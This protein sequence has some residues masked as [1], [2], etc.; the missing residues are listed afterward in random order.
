MPLVVLCGFPCSGKS[1]RALELQEYLIQSGK[2]V[3]IIG[4]EALGVNR[5]D[6]YAD[7]R[8]EKDVRGSLRAEVERKLNKEDV[9]ILDSLNYIKGYRYELFCLIKHVQTPHCLI[10][11]ITAPEISSTWNQERDKNEQ[12]T[13]EIFDALVQ[14]FEAPDSRNRWDSPLF[15]VHKEEKLPMEQICSAIFHRRA[16]PPNQS[17]QT[18]P[19]SSTNF[20]HEL[21]KVTQDVVTAVLNAQ[22]T[23]IPGDVIAVPGASER[24]SF[25]MKLPRILN[26][27]EL[28]RLRQQFISYTKLH[29]NENISQLANMFV[30]SLEGRERTLAAAEGEEARRKERQK[31]KQWGRRSQEQRQRAEEE[32]LSGESDNVP[33]VVRDVLGEGST[34]SGE[35]TSS[36][37]S[38]S[39]ST[40]SESDSDTNANVQGNANRKV[41]G[42]VRKC[43]R[44]LGDKAGKRKGSKKGVD[45]GKSVKLAGPGGTT[46]CA[47]SNPYDH[48]PKKI[49]RRI[50]SGKFVD[51]FKLTRQAVNGRDGGSKGETGEHRPKHIMDWVR[52]FY[53]FSSFYLLCHPE[54]AMNVMRYMDLITDTHTVYGGTAWFEYDRAFRLKMADNEDMT[55]GSR[56]M[57]L[58]SGLVTHARG[59]VP[60]HTQQRAPLQGAKRRDQCYAFNEGACKRGFGCKFRQACT[61]CGGGTP[62]ACAIRSRGAKGLASPFVMA[63]GKAQSPVDIEELREA[64]GGYPLRKEARFL[65]D[66]FM[67]GFKVPVQGEVAQSGKPRNLKSAQEYPQVVR[68]KLEKELRA[69][70]MAGPSESPP[71]R[72]LIVSPLGVVPKREPGKF[73]LIQH[74]SYPE[75]H[76]VNDAIDEAQC[77][78][79]Y[80]SF[81]QALQLVI[82]AGP[83]ALMAKLDIESAFRLLPLH[84]SSFRYMGCWFQGR[85]YVDRCLPMG[86]SVSCAFFEVFSSF[87][88]WEVELR[89]GSVAHYLDDFMFV[90]PRDSEE[91]GESLELALARFKV[92]VVPVAGDKTVRPTTRLTFLGIEIDSMD[93]LV[94]L[95][96]EKV[97][98]ARDQVRRALGASKLQLRVLQSLLGTL[99]FATRVIPM[100]RVF[101]R[102]LEQATVGVKQPFH[103]VRV[104]KQLK[105]DLKVWETF[106][107]DF[108]GVRLWRSAPESSAE[109]QLETD[110]SAVA[111]K[112]R[113]AVI[114]GHSF[115]Y[116]AWRR[117]VRKDGR[118]QLGIP[119]ERLK[120]NWLGKRGLKWGQV[121]DLW[122]AAV[123]RWGRPHVV[124]IH[125]GGNDLA[126]VKTVDLICQIKD[127]CQRIMHSCPENT[128]AE[129]HVPPIGLCPPTE[130]TTV[131]IHAEV[132]QHQPQRLCRFYS[133]GRYCQF[134]RRCRFLHQHVVH[135]SSEK[136][137]KPIVSSEIPEQGSAT[138]IPCIPNT[139]GSHSGLNKKRM[140][141]PLRKYRPKKL[142]RYFASGYC[143]M[144]SNCRFWHPQKL[145]PISDIRPTNKKPAVTKTEARPPVE[146]PAA[147]PEDMKVGD[148]TPEIARQLRESEVSLLLKRFPK[149]KVIIQEREDKEVTYY[150]VTVEPTDPD[151]PFDLKEM[152]IL[153]EFP[154][155]YPLQVFTVQVPEDQDLPSVMGRHVSEVSVAWLQGKHATNQL[156]GKVELLFRPYL[157]WLDRNMERLFTEGARLLKRDIDA[158]KAGL[159]FV[160]YQQLQAA[161]VGTSYK[162]GH[163]N[164]SNVPE[165][166]IQET[167]DGDLEDDSDSWTSCDEDDEPE[168]GTTAAA[169]DGM[170]SI[171]SGGVVGPRKGT[172]IRFLGSRLGE[173]VGTVV[174]N[175]I[176]VSLQCSRC[177]MTADLSLSGKQPCTAQC[178]RCNSRISGTFQPSIMHPFSAVMGYVNI[179]GAAPKELILQDCVFM[180]GCLTCSQEGPLQNLS[181]GIPKDLNCLHCHSKLSI[182]TEAA[183]FQKVERYPGKVNDKGLNQGRK[184]PLKD[185]SI[186]PGKPLPDQGTCR[187]Y[188]KSFRWLRFP[189]CGKAYP[190][191]ICHDE[192]E[193]H[194]MELASRMIC[195]HCAKEQ[196]YSNGKPCISC[197]NMVTR[198]T[199]SVH[200]EGGR[201]CRNKVK[202][203][204]KDKQKYSNSAK[205][206][207]RRSVTKK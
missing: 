14:R 10:Y 5:N 198:S 97:Q 53:A 107:E 90:G 36:A 96:L 55:F 19:L 144:E 127:T 134:G 109:L 138:E 137:L 163:P 30:Q 142:C 69:G 177:K 124:V 68:D 94:R 202:M 141:V 174:A 150:R 50:V 149:D 79:Q 82:D 28:R 145:P 54:E 125:A 57:D 15:T 11:C 102:R 62:R 188:R 113:K 116:W 74:L 7:S 123:E 75:G 56:D 184:K 33:C 29:P 1:S 191:D 126:E 93:K 51:V 26:M 190:C 155:D 95:P 164:Q 34:D 131:Q 166:E 49:R 199:Q 67:F 161:A 181:Y 88:H 192:G 86:Y 187:H 2:K 206:V 85:Y 71:L 13:Q 76:S 117:A 47:L 101:S 118:G 81:E 156:V 112:G 201:G 21:D 18:Q 159:E 114:L 160:P 22:K 179:L 12:Y 64:L 59:A 173:G 140:E 17:T 121:W 182:F 42:L 40:E 72:D 44:K 89:P 6:V 63:L 70:R 132:N 66:G 133:Q 130:D 100:G 176:T 129:S 31:D 175:R 178:E 189:C 103:W 165:T 203:S 43:L 194:E 172:E 168:P 108:N 65:L 48:V 135:P 162:E 157:H 60:A 111:S 92:L 119:Q 195:G 143:A 153:L 45:V 110:A 16:P 87:L 180:I 99:N 27:S 205:T 185:P 4:D 183:K 169:R 148:I 186:Q 3:F 39:D 158:E 207:S 83:G 35:S 61:K 104:T 139:S 136:S 122:L 152:E 37:G 170:Q 98:L 84:P 58:W 91:C 78:V 8:K 38:D 147:L 9:V 105:E 106:L 171:E 120:V 115:V 193:D 80:Q 73:C 32:Q 200:W 204:R 41:V 151:W 146:R 128:M 52:G 77:S 46:L 23:S 20:L 197:G 196:P 24:I 25:E 167:P 154:A